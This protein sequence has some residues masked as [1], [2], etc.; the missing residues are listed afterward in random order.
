MSNSYAKRNL[1]FF[2]K[3]TNRISKIIVRTV[4]K[5]ER[6]RS[7]CNIFKLQSNPIYFMLDKKGK[8][9][10]RNSNGQQKNK[11]KFLQLSPNWKKKVYF[12]PHTTLMM[13]GHCILWHMFICEIRC[14]CK[15]QKMKEIGVKQV[16]VYTDK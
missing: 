2:Q 6:C 9:K 15:T 11:F 1:S 8:K 3:S 16:F 10:L 7:I 4:E 12:I 13:R 14:Y 5:W